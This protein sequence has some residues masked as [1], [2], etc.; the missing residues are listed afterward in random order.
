MPT[1]T[2]CMKSIRMLV[3]EKNFEDS[4][5]DETIFGKALFAIMELTEALEIIKKNGIEVLKHSKYLRNLV[6][7]ELIDSMFYILDLYGILFRE[8]VA[9]NPDEVFEYKLNKN[10]KR[11]FR[12]GRPS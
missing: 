10:L 6:S 7:E 1:L 2:E 11:R 12:Y 9:D 3:K 8:G 4:F 5:N